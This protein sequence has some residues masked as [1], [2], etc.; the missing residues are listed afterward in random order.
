MTEQAFISIGSNISPESYLPRAVR[1]LASL[2]RVAAVSTV[3]QSRS[4]GSRP[5][6]D[7]L[8]AVARLETDWAPLAL[9]QRLRDI[10]TDLDRLRSE[11]AY[12]PR[13]I[14]LDLTLYG[15]ALLDTPELTLPSPE[16]M[17][18]SFVAVPLADL[19]PD[20]PH[21]ITGESLS[22]IAERLASRFRLTPRDDLSSIISAQLE[23]NPHGGGDGN[24]SIE[25]ETGYSPGQH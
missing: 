15:S 4:L 24:P 18:R 17:T 12:A 20:F 7:F 22:R 21:P 5:Q 3:Y 25:S 16:I 23:M 19:A 6:P 13:T 9:R 14:D 2:G 1:G 11:D 10:E 8:N